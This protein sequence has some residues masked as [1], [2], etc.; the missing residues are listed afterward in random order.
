MKQAF[1]AANIQIVGGDG[2][3]FDRFVNAVTMGRSIDGVVDNSKTVKALAGDYLSGKS[4]L[5]A[6]LKEVLSRPALNAESLQ[7]LSVAAVLT[8]LAGQSDAPG[9]R[10]IEKI[11]EQLKGLG[12]DETPVE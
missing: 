5:P 10:K 2:A 1:A 9:K 11:I 12:L 7:Q 4:S 6:D 3:F 8:K